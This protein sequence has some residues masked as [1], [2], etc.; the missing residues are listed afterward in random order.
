MDSKA[1]IE[2]L[3][4]MSE[5]CSNGGTLSSNDMQGL[6][7]REAADMLETNEHIDALRTAAAE[8]IRALEG[9]LEAA[10]FETKR[11]TQMLH[12]E[13]TYS[14]TLEAKLRE[15]TKARPAAPENYAVWTSLDYMTS[16]LD[17]TVKW[18]ALQS[19]MARKSALEL[20]A[21]VAYEGRFRAVCVRDSD[22]NFAWWNI[23]DPPQS[24]PQ[25]QP[26][27][28]D[29]AVT[30]TWEPDS[31]RVVVTYDNAPT[32]RVVTRRS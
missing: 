7:L 26:Q 4:I 12:D 18:A 11:A 22:H 8:R 17:P 19:G 31:N 32:V 3:R 1:I 9:Q 25:P 10:Q 21:E 27:P 30:I 15:A 16:P 20:A 23:A 2:K 13:E 14:A 28:P 6:A 24:Q 5:V 29:N